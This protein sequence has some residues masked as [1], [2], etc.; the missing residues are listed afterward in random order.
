MTVASDSKRFAGW[1]RAT[2][3]GGLLFAGGSLPGLAGW[4]YETDEELL[5]AG[6]L[7]GDGRPDL[8]VLDRRT[9][10]LR[11][12]Y[13]GSSDTVNWAAPRS[14]G[15]SAPTGLALGRFLRQNQQAICVASPR[16]NRV[17]FLDAA[18]P[19][20]ASAPRPGYPMGL[21]PRTLAA[22]ISPFGP[23][24]GSQDYLASC[25]EA[26]AEVAGQRLDLSIVSAGEVSLGHSVRV[27]QV[28]EG[29]NSFEFSTGGASF[30]GGFL[31]GGT[32]DSFLLYQFTNTLAEPATL[33]GMKPG[34]QAVFG[35]FS[36][37]FRLVFYQPGVVGGLQVHTADP[38]APNVVVSPG[39]GL[40]AWGQP[41]RLIET[42]TQGASALLLV[43]F[44]GD[45]GAVLYD[46]AAGDRLIEKQRFGA[47]GGERITAVL[48]LG[49]GRIAVMSSADAGGRSQQVQVF[50]SNGTQFVL[51]SQSTLPGIET[52]STRASL[53]LFDREP[54]VS[55][56]PGFIGALATGDWVSSVV[57]LPNAATATVEQDRGVNLG[58]GVP[59][60][61]ALSGLPAAARFGLPNQY[62]PALSFFSLRSASGTEPSAATL[63]PPPGR[64]SGPVSLTL[65]S[66][67]VG[68]RI[69]FRRSPEASWEAYSSAFVISNTTT[70]SYYVAAG[71]LDVRSRL[72]MALYEF[73]SS[74]EPFTPN[75]GTNLPP[76]AFAGDWQ[77]IVVKR[78]MTIFLDGTASRDPE[79]GP[80][81][82]QWA[83][84]GGP[85]VTL[86]GPRTATPSFVTP[87]FSNQIVLRFQLR[88]TDQQQA[89][90]LSETAFV[91]DDGCTPLVEEQVVNQVN[92]DGSFSGAL[93]WPGLPGDAVIV[94]ASEDL[95]SW[96]EIGRGNASLSGWILFRD[97]QSGRYTRRFYRAT[98]R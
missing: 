30:L 85:Q 71:T 73:P 76:R 7:D 19:A 89:V 38:A 77:R 60:A 87:S 33:L 47:P 28:L 48:P 11:L 10:N 29:L 98:G 97:L 80:L 52:A 93:E 86:I 65:R 27:P 39:I 2:V 18:N 90:A 1:L 36:T 17:M 62:H 59:S 34:S 67:N 66:A 55:S 43:I 56:Q 22:M 94:E 35:R 51:A 25:S 49:A 41:V 13:L 84:T 91:L 20:Q 68:D 4:T 57:G 81:L 70:V 42:V 78:P 24:V 3:L 58:L 88:V 96:Q 79:G 83:Q 95:E 63:S 69:Y 44:E 12:G 21:G 50:R 92:P 72:E 31:R 45:P 32:S 75:G 15:I 5:A 9:G 40:T 37:G 14:S 74:P 26:E 8:V 54:F 6:D 16:A 23:G 61:K 53:F 46:L 64:Y 82:Y